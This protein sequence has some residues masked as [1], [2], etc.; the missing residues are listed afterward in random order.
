MQ[1]LRQEQRITK[2]VC[3]KIPRDERDPEGFA[4]H[5]EVRHPMGL[6]TPSHSAV[7]QVDALQGSNSKKK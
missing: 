6:Q 7:S 1:T 2:Q 5:A 3:G 4:E